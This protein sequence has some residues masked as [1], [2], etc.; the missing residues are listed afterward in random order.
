MRMR[1]ITAGVALSALT[2]VAS[3]QTAEERASARQVVAQRADAVVTLLGTVS[4][5]MS[6]GGQP[7]P[8]QEQQ[9][10]ASA[11]L[12]DNTGLAVLSLA[13][14]EPIEMFNQMAAAAA[15]MGRAKPGMTI[16]ATDLRIRLADGREVPVRIVLR[17]REQDLLFVRPTSAPASP[18]PSVADAAA[19]K[20]QLLD[21]VVSL[22]RFGSV[23]GWQI[24]ASLGHVR[25]VTDK[26]RTL[27]VVSSAAGDS[28]LGEPVFDLSG[29]FV[30]IVVMRATGDVSGGPEA[31]LQAV[32]VPAADIRDIAQRAK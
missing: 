19:S 8:A 28:A 21:F 23:L 31:L 18:L 6:V 24:G 26:P 27:Y 12:L 30:G 1:A 25:A 7:A 2:G 13:T 17:D 32:V 15:A 20:P 5:H 3:A 29:R 10:R 22:R 4:V 9:V 11:T 14:L 16:T